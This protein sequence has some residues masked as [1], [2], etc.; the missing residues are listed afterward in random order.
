MNGN[1]LYTG[2]NLYI[3]HGMDSETV[4][5]VVANRYPCITRVRTH[6]Q[7]TR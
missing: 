2:D 3:L 1:T 7:R 5:N 4:D 6:R